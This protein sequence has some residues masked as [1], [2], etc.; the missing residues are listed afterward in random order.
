M[1]KNNYVKLFRS[2]LKHPIWKNLEY[3]TGKAWIELLILSSSNTYCF[4]VVRYDREV[5]SVTLHP[6]QQYVFPGNLAKRWGWSVQKVNDFLNKL[7]TENAFKN[8]DGAMIAK[9]YP[10][11]I[12]LGKEMIRYGMRV[13]ILNWE[14]YQ[15]N[16][17]EK[18]LTKKSTILKE[19]NK[20][21][22]LSIFTYWNEMKIVKHKSIKRFDKHI[23]SALK[24]YTESEIK[25]AI[26]LYGIVLHD[27]IYWWD[28]RWGLR[29][30]LLRGL[31]K[32]MPDSEPLETY[33]IRGR[34]K[35]EKQK[36][37]LSYM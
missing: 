1:A 7:A 37:K 13:T 32:F 22:R 3:D 9:D 2:Q 34:N 30:F 16:N 10:I 5:G 19:L 14:L 21:E 36:P 18:E 15:V 8:N 26:R 11:K 27:K 6:G 31:E 29:E 24:N 17:G 20:E 33:K 28:Y 25:E 23:N 35:F 12:P 4:Q